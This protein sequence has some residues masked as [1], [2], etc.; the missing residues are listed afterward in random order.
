MFHH[1]LPLSHVVGRPS[2]NLFI[3]EDRST[4]NIM[5]SGTSKKHLCIP[6]IIFSNL[7]LYLAS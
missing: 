4:S 5:T 6:M 1:Y 7:N 3:F 2:D